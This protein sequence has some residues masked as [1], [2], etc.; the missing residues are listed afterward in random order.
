MEITAISQLLTAHIWTTIRANNTAA[1]LVLCSEADLEAIEWSLKICAYPDYKAN[2]LVL[3]S[4]EECS[5]NETLLECYI[6]NKYKKECGLKLKQS[7]QAI[8]FMVK[9]F[10]LTNCARVFGT[11]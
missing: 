1:I 2:P 5:G 8:D 7:M 10:S 3:F 6:F 9:N 4:V 11:S